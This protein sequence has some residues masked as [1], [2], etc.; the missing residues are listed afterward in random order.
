M[1]RR[2]DGSSGDLQKRRE[3]SSFRD[4]SGYLFWTGDEIFRHVA[5]SYCD[6][7]NR[8]LE[9]GLMASLIERGLVLP[10]SLVEDMRLG[11][12]A[13]VLKPQQISL[14]TYPYE[15]CFEQLK[16]AALA[17]LDVH[18]AALEHDMM[19]K[20][21]S[22][23][24]IQF[25][26]GRA[27]LIDHLSIDNL[28]SHPAWPAYGQFCRH[29]LAPLALMAY[30]DLRLSGLA[31]HYIDGVPLDLA[32]L[33]LPRHT[34]LKFGLAMHLHLHARMSTRHANTNKSV[35]GKPLSKAKHKAFAESLR[36]TV[37]KLRPK[38]QSTEWGNYYSG[39]N[40]SDDA[41]IAKGQ[42]V[43]EL[44]QRCGAQT[45]WDLGGN[46][47]RFTRSI[48]DLAN[49]L[50]TLDIDP[51]AVSANYAACRRDNITN[52]L[53]LVF[54]CCNPTPSI[55]FANKERPSLLQRGKPD[56]TLALALIH[57]LAISNNLPLSDIADFFAGISRFVI[58]EFV[59]K[60]D[61]QVERLLLNREDVFTDYTIEKFRTDFSLVFNIIEERQ[62]PGS[63]RT[64]FLLERRIA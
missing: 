64:L 13:T 17:T 40:Y 31:I 20:D 5:P 27:C 51:I 60:A 9:S 18:L 38:P 23:F 28:S 21:A 37:Q 34:R 19:L 46:D 56:L 41:A 49:E 15:W 3:F 45:I 58:I 26:R 12:G 8:A 62:I 36:S 48:A 7:L 4:P 61:S 55:G 25:V 1:Q 59:P 32:S 63:V 42:M 35:R 30:T 50:V 11:A 14:I 53:P 22:A 2:H 52:V 6:T 44:V 24:N 54:D 57:H 16:E 43:R 33:L 29:F 39:T 47:G 10:F